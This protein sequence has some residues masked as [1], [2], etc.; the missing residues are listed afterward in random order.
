[1]HNVIRFIRVRHLILKMG[2]IGT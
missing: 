1:M 2:N